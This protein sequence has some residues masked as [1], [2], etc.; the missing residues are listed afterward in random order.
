P[1]GA[2]VFPNWPVTLTS[3]NL[4]P[5]VAEGVPNAGVIGTFNGTRAA[6]MHGNATPPLL[7]PFDPG[8]Q[9]LLA[10]TPPNAIPQRPDPTHPGQTSLG[11]DPSSIFGT[12]SKAATPNTMLPLFAQ[13]SL[14]D[15]DQD[16]TPDVVASGGSLNLAINLQQKG[17]TGLRGDN[18]IAMWSGKTGA[19]LPA[20]PMVLEDFTFFNSQAIADLD[21]DNY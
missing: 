17:N 2:F 4:F 18:L 8:A 5:L 15:I 9:P 11:V 14:G 6:V 1:G 20:S 16:G 12:L 7:L 13:P 21:G 3:F 10:A 19:M